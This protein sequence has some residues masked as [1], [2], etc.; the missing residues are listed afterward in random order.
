MLLPQAER[1]GEIHFYLAKSLPYG[2]RMAISFLLMAVGFL[3]IQ[4]ARPKQV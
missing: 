1:R 3:I 4:L 2:L